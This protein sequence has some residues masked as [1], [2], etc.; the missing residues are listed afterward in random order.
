LGLFDSTGYKFM[1]ACQSSVYTMGL[2]FSVAHWLVALL[3]VAILVP[4]LDL[5]DN[6]FINCLKSSDF[7]LSILRKLTVK[8]TKGGK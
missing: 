8:I 4:G 6:I 1:Y 3:D 7:Q 2:I 5:Y